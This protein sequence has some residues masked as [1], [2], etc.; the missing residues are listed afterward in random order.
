MRKWKP[1]NISF[2]CEIRHLSNV[3]L[4]ISG[5]KWGAV[6]TILMAG[7]KAKGNSAMSSKSY[8]LSLSLTG[9]VGVSS[10]GQSP[11]TEMSGKKDRE[12]CF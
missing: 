1:R 2:L 8:T 10:C 6:R 3:P 11:Y 7:S 9:E 4:K 12:Y 5:W